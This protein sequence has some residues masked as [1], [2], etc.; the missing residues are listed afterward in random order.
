[1]ERRTTARKVLAMHKRVRK[2]MLRFLFNAK[3]T[4]RRER[5]G[6][7]RIPVCESAKNSFPPACATF[8][9]PPPPP[10]NRQL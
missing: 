5:R 7:P 2:R 9:P 6:R 4:G 1:M 10:E 8:F 3:A